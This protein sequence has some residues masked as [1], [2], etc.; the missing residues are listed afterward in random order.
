MVA[1]KSLADGKIKLGLL[2]VAP[3]DPNAP[4]LSEIEASLDI[5]CRIAKTPYTLGP[6]TSESINDPELCT[7]VNATVWGAS[8]FEGQIA[9]FRYFDDVTGL[10]DE[11]GDEVFQALK[12]KGI[13]VWLVERDS[14]KKSTEDWTAGDEV[15]IYR[16]ILDNPKK[17]SDRGG[18]I[19]RIVDLAIQEGFLDKVIVA[20]P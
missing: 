20:G 14:H 15:S 10:V 12:T 4:T 16:A 18:F 7:D 13:E 9:P 11:T 1:V 19:K 17:P 5:S 3:V 6:T 8:N 2:P